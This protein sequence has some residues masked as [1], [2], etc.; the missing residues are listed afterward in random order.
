MPEKVFLNDRIIDSD[1]ACVSATD[2][3]LL[4]GAGLFETMRSLNGVVF[5]LDDHLNRLMT[6]AAALSIEHSYGKNQLSDA[7]YGVLQ[8]NELTDARIRL[9]LTSGSMTQTEE[10]HRPT[11]LIT[12]VTFQPYPPQYYKTGVMALLC[13]YRQNS[14]DPTCGHKTTSYYSRLLAL[15]HAHRSGAAEALWFTTDNRLAEGCVSN[16]FLVKDST[17]FTPPVS[18]PV[19][20]G[21][22]RRTVLE[23][24]G[25]ESIQLVEKDLHVADVLEADEVFLTNVIMTACPVVSVEKHTVGDGKVG[26]IATK[27]QEEFMRTIE[28]QCRRNT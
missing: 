2:G 15:R 18:T 27:L 14:S 19:L 22:A 5:R 8:A 12:A 9:T 10:Q 20:P 23:I 11:L 13:P 6:S 1:Q 28:E 24:A 3:G 7:I 26:P 16:V 21:I 25:R 17:L 4:Y